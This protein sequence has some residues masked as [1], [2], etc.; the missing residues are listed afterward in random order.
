MLR[1]FWAVALATPLFVPLA[2]QAAS[3]I[4]LD[5][6][7]DLALASDPTVKASEAGTSAS[8]AN[9]KQ[10]GRLPNPTIGITAENFGGTGS[11]SGLRSAEYT[12]SYGQMIEVGGDRSAREA[13]ASGDLKLANAR[14]A[15]QRLE[16]VQTVRHAYILALASETKLKVVQERA[17]FISEMNRTVRQRS[18][19]GRDSSMVESQARASAAEVAVDLMQAERAV[20]LSRIQLSTLWNGVDD[21][22]VLDQAFFEKPSFDADALP[23][24]QGYPDLAQYNALKSRATANITLEKARAIPDPEISAGIRRFASGSETAFIVGLSIPFPVYD[25]NRNNI[26]RAQSERLQADLEEVAARRDINLKLASAV[27]RRD[28]A[29]AEI[30]ALRADA[31]PQATQAL[32]LARSGY[33]RGAFSY[34][35]IADASRGLNALRERLVGALQTFHENQI[36]IDRLTGRSA[37]TDKGEGYRP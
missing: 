28:S 13:V 9:L 23:V 11:V 16:T 29:R 27:A 21:G 34:L 24:D 35:E 1:V 36:T 22:F 20:K 15:T 12:L 7:I 10:A 19:Q 14:L 8:L 4:T 2:V 3:L 17:S 5:Q 18:R 32:E 26:E 6:A 31:I 25:S 37:I 33:E 30:E